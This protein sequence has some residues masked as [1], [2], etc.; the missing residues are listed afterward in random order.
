MK[1]KDKFTEIKNF[2]SIKNKE[3]FN[4]EILEKINEN[5]RFGH[6]FKTEIFEK[7]DSKNNF[8]NIK[9]FIENSENK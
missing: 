6:N 4:S 7:I 9:E 5:E 8:K 1:F 3:M 2:N